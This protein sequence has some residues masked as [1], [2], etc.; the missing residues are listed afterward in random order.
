MKLIK[1]NRISDTVCCKQELAENDEKTGTVCSNNEEFQVGSCDIP[2][3]GM[4]TVL[5]FSWDDI[6]WQTD[7]IN[8]IGHTK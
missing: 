3:Q 7:M 6:L 1:L 2:V 4:S 5:L 8:H